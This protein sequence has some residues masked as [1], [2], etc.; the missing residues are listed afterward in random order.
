SHSGGPE[1]F[2]R[3]I[4]EAWAHRK[5]VIAFAAGAPA[6]LI[7]HEQDGLLVPEADVEALAAALARLWGDPDLCR[8]LGEAGYRKAA[9]RYEAKAVTHQLVDALGLGA[10]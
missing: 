2:G 7:A 4:I 1:T 5:P 6:R 9:A 8:R 3:A 10:S